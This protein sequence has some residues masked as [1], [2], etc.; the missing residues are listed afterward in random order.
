MAGLAFSY[1]LCSLVKKTKYQG[2]SSPQSP[3]RYNE[4][5][6]ERWWLGFITAAKTKQRQKKIMFFFSVL[7][8]HSAEKGFLCCDQRTWVGEQFCDKTLLSLFASMLVVVKNP[9][10][11]ISDGERT[12]NNTPAHD[13]FYCDTRERKSLMSCPRFCLFNVADRNK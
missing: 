8:L 12:F 2:L 5:H 9:R 13:A 4:I 6:T 1:G 11:A 7:L 3:T 10:K